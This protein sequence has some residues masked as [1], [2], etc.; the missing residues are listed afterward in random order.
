MLLIKVGGSNPPY[1]FP[2]YLFISRLQGA[3]GWA[4]RAIACCPYKQ[5][6][7]TMADYTRIQVAKIGPSP[8][9]SYKQR[10]TGY[11]RVGN[12]IAGHHGSHLEPKVLF[13][14][15]PDEL[16]FSKEE[17]IGLTEKEAEELFHKKDIAYLQS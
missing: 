3:A 12:G 2:I 11:I 9:C 4:D 6:I 15:Y 1:L 5:P 8:D 16:S 7:E 14:F 10:V 13:D 17:F